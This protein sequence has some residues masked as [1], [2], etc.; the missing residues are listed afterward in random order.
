MQKRTKS[1]AGKYSRRKGRAFEQAVARDFRA[2]YGENVKRG[3]QAREG[4][5]APDVDG[6]PWWVECK[7]HARVNVQA[8]FQQAVD[9]STKVG[10]RGFERARRPAVLVHHDTG[11]EHTLVTLKLEDFLQLCTAQDGYAA[12]KEISQQH[13]ERS[14]DDTERPVPVTPEG[15][16]VGVPLAQPPRK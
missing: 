13:A 15:V 9:A 7:H 14:A 6:T 8:S 2:I 5:D 16:R 3:W 12:L 10:K 1:A 4:F 11:K